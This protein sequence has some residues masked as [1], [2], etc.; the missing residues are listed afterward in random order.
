MIVGGKCNGGEWKINKE[1]REDME[2]LKYLGVWFDRG[3]RGNVQLERTRGKVRNGAMNLLKRFMIFAMFIVHGCVRLYKS[4][5]ALGVVHHI[6]A[7]CEAQMTKGNG[8]YH[9]HP[10]ISNDISKVLDEMDHR[11]CLHPS[12]K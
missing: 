3:M 11:I 2:V 12:P 9:S 10:R 1:R 6:C 5:E 7:F 8:N 4:W